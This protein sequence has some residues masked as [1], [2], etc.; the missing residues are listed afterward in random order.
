MEDETKIAILLFDNFTAL[1]VVGLYEV[2]SKIPNS[3]IYFVSETVRAYKD[4]K[5][6]QIIA[7][8]SFDSL[9]AADIIV[10]PGGFGID[11]ILNNSRVINWV[12]GVHAQSKWTVSVC[13]GALLLGAA[14]LLKDCT[15]TTHWNRKE[16]LAQY[17]SNITDDRYV[18]DGKIITSAGVS[19][20]IDMALYLLSLVTNET[21]AKVVQLGMEYDPQPPFNTGSPRTAP[22]ELVDLIKNQ[23]KINA[24]T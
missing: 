14:G 6:L 7:D 3:R 17:C 23:R 22:K 1:D 21:Y 11:A 2:L 19:A 13:S 24:A 18:V 15:A 4:S 12:K 8:S 10:L 9:P 5:G 16:Q 20:G